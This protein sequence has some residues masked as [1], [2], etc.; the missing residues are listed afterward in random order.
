MKTYQVSVTVNVPAYATVEIE[1]TSQEEAE[2]IAAREIKDDEWESDIW[3]NL[4]FT[5]AWDEAEGLCVS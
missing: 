3:Q 5:P 2:E 4:V 1:A